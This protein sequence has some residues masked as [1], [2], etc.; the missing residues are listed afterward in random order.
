MDNNKKTRIVNRYPVETETREFVSANILEVEVGT[1]GYCGGDT[2]HGCRTYFRLK[3]LSST[4]I[5]V[6]F[7]EDEGLEIELGG[8]CELDTFID[9][10]EFAIAKLKEQRKG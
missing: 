6:Y 10:L 7:S 9:C 4:D 3:D 5:E 1:T 2:G 8:D